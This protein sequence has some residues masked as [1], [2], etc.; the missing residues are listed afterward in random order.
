M[1]ASGLA[2][3]TSNNKTMLQLGNGT[4]GSPSLAGSAG[5]PADRPLVGSCAELGGRL[6]RTL[7]A[8]SRCLTNHA[9]PSGNAQRHGTRKRPLCNV[10]WS[11]RE[12]WLRV[13]VSTPRK[14][15]APPPR[16]RGD[17]D[18]T[19]CT[20]RSSRRFQYHA[21]EGRLCLCHRLYAR[22]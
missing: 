12:L 7:R 14:A 9:T 16:T 4:A 19:S 22:E 21:S 15:R 8:S 10:T 3:I 5:V 11:R 2:Q 18:S 1:H 6:T 20:Q 17:P 13:V